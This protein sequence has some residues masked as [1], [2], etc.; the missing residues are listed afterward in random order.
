MPSGSLDFR[1]PIENP[2]LWRQIYLELRERFRPQPPPDLHLES[3]PVPVKS[4]WSRD[5]RTRER[6]VSVAIHIA[7]IAILLLPFW[8]P[9]RPALKTE[10]VEV[11]P[12]L[13]APGPSLP[14]RQ[15]LA[16]GGAPIV[17]KLAAPKLLP[18]DA[19]KPMVAPPIKLIPPTAEPNL[20]IPSFG[21]PGRIAG[22]PGNSAGH[23]GAGPGGAGNDPNG[24]GNCVTGPCATGGDVTEPVPLYEPD[25]QYSDAARKAK[26][27]GTV[28]VEVVIGSDGHVYN[29]RI[30]QPLGLGL[31][32]KA[33]AAVMLWR[34]EPAKRHGQ[35]VQVAANIEVN[36]RLY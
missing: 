23:S 27:Q 6:V 11:F 22:P 35:P 33:I 5:P 16:G 12:T 34:F 8:S 19:P 25:P 2:P 3:T 13:M 17:H 31:D 4:I 7:I 32:Q 29:P 30:V 14:K 36:F 15:H 18:V 24:G 21:D 10:Q 20:N 26:F 1:P 28:V 9:V